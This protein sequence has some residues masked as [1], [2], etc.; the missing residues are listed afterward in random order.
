M[1]E[2]HKDEHGEDH[3]ESKGHGGHGGGGHGGGH[4]EHEEGGCPEWM[5]SFADNTA[6]MMGLFVIL[7][8]MNM[9]PK[10][11]SIMG[12]E[13]SEVEIS[14]AAQTESMLDFAISVREAFNNPVD[15]GSSEP[16]DEMLRER[17]KRRQMQGESKSPG[18][19]GRERNVDSPRPSDYYTPG[20][21]VSFGHNSADLSADSRQ[22]AA[23]IAAQVRGM[24]WVIEVRGHASVSETFRNPDKG[25]RLSFDRASA[26][27]RALVDNGVKWSQMRL[28]ACG[29]S[30][31]AGAPSGDAAQNAS[32]ER[33]QVLITQE[34]IPRDPF[35]LD[36]TGAKRGEA[37]VPDSPPRASPAGDQTRDAGEDEH[38]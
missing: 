6:L 31:P 17:I 15:M 30:A 23:D 1:A 33:V 38:H 37:P 18:N 13:P 26:V 34:L 20:G 36:R 16:R 8:A 21:V 9:G 7:L 22:V 3:G 10:A 24:R 14:Q 32:S 5:I 35:S 25:N 4:G 28:V 29:D 2:T 27:A 12:G 19:P 11:T